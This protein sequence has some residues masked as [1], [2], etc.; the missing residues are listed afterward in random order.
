MLAYGEAWLA[1]PP[2]LQSRELAQAVP[3]LEVPLASL[4]RSNGSA[5][6]PAAEATAARRQ[7]MAPLHAA[8]LPYL[9]RLSE[10]RRTGEK[11]LLGFGHSEGFLQPGLET[12]MAHD[13]PVKA[14]AAGPFHNSFALT[15]DGRVYSW[16]Y[17]AYGQLGLGQ[18]E[19]NVREPREIEALRGQ[20]VCTMAAGVYHSLAA[21]ASGHAFG[22]G[23]RADERLGLG[24]GAD[25]RVPLQY[26]GLKLKPQA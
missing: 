5:W 25:Q 19:G 12:S 15:R 1:L 9:R 22:W 24:T 6:E 21:S 18:A 13:A 14:V 8:S 7:A 3:T 26:A 23:F 2:S 11:P 10:A 4:E 17:S 20:G 16:G